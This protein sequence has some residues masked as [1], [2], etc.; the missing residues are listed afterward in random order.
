MDRRLRASGEAGPPLTVPALARP[1]THA[2]TQRVPISDDEHRLADGYVL[3]TLGHQNGGN[4]SI[5]LRLPAYSSLVRFDIADELARGD[6]LTEERE[7]E[8]LPALCEAGA[9]VTHEGGHQ[10]RQGAPLRA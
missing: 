10:P 8:E 6:L 7:R 4:V 2:S 3:G 1:G 9:S 5:L